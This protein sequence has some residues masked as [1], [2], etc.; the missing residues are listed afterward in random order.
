MK[1]ILLPKHKERLIVAITEFR[2][3]NNLALHDLQVM[4]GYQV[5]EAYIQQILAGKA[6]FETTLALA[7]MLPSLD[8][9]ININ[10]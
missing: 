10:L 4:T 3:A 9:H 8:V 2:D 1:S 7:E 6:S 5:S